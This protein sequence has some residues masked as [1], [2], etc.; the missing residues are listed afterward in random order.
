LPSSWNS[1]ETGKGWSTVML[2]GLWLWNMIPLLLRAQAGVSGQA[3]LGQEAVGQA[4][5]VGLERRLV[6]QVAELAVQL[7]VAGIGDPDHAVV[8]HEG[9]R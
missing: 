4:Q 6:E 7:A 8:D 5:A 9:L 2:S 1:T 3:A